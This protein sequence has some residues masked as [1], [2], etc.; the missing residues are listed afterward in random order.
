MAKL[1]LAE[2]REGVA[3][4]GVLVINKP[5]GWTS[6]DVVA[7]ARKLLGVSKIGHTGTLD[8]AATGV[9]VLCLGKAT[10]I[11][12]YLVNTD[13][14]YRAVLRLGA[15][16][17]TQDATGN[18]VGRTEGALPDEA[19]ITAAMASFVGRLQQVPPMYSAIKVKGVPLYKSAR[20]GRT[21]PRSPREFTVRSLQ[22]LSIASGADGTKDVTFDVV[23]SKGTYVR[24]LCADIGEALGVGGH[25]AGLERRRV[26]RFSIED[27]LSLDALAELAER[28]AVESRLYSTAVALTDLPALV[29]DEVASR[30]IRHGVA[31]PATRVVQAKGA[32]AVGESVCL[33]GPDGRLLAIGKV[34]CGPEDLGQAAPGT[35]IKLEKVLV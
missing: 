12:E 26:G 3:V 11:A 25:L 2:R 4:D 7:K 21:V 30:S 32:W 31:V 15:A 1:D 24:T 28:E 13:K 33:L 19:A 18:V 10:R 6:H 16:T 17:D 22:I 27:A 5:A 35:L 34:P 23:C 8:P 20:A 29:I 9:L 14:E